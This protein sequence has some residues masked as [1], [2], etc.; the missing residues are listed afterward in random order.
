MKALW[1]VA[2]LALA[3]LIFFADII[4][5]PDIYLDANPFH[6]DPWRTYASQ[7]D[8]EHRTYRTDSFVTYLPRR[9]ELTRSLRQGRFPLWNP[10][11][12]GGMPFFADPQTRVLY[13]LAL[14]LTG[15]DPLRSMGYDV[16]IHIFIA[17]LGMFL[18]MR[19]IKISILGSLAAAFGYAFSSFFYVRIGHPTFVATASWIPFFFLGFERARAHG[20]QGVLLLALSFVLGYLAGFPQVFLFGV[21]SVV[22]YGF[23]LA[24]M[25]Q[26]EPGRLRSLRATTEVFAIAGGLALLLVCVQLIPFVELS[27][28]SVGLSIDLSQMKEVFVTPP[29]LLL[30]SV[31]PN[32]FGNPVEGTDWSDL[33]REL[34]HP[35]NPDFT[36]YCGIA[37]LMLGLVS[38]LHLKR[39]PRIQVLILLLLAS[40]GIATSPVLVSIAYK[41]SPVFRAS[42]ISRIAVVSCF[43][44]S[45]L[46]GMGFDFLEACRKNKKGRRKALAVVL[47]I[48]IFAI[49]FALFWSIAGR[50]VIARYA[51]KAA[52]VPETMW[53]RLHSYTRS[54]LIKVW[55]QADID[56]WFGYEQKQIA[57]GITFAALSALFVLA[58]TYLHGKAP[59][60]KILYVLLVIFIFSDIAL[61]AKG[62]FV[63]QVP[64]CLFETRGIKFLKDAL[65]Q[66]GTWRMMSS[67]ITKAKEIPVLP[68]NTNLLFSLFACDGQSTIVP[69]AYSDLT[70]AFDEIT[71]PSLL[72]RRTIPLQVGKI[73]MSNLGCTRYVLLSRYSKMFVSNPIL[74]TIGQYEETAKNLRIV[75]L[76]GN[77]RLAID[78]PPGDMLNLKMEFPDVKFLDFVVGFN[79]N[80]KSPGDT[81]RFGIVCEGENSS[82]KALIEFD[83]LKDR[84]KWHPQRLDVSNLSGLVHLRLGWNIPPASRV[85]ANAYWSGIDLVYADCEPETIPGGYLIRFPKMA[86]SLR[87]K[88]KTCAR[89]VPLEV[90]FSNSHKRTWWTAF[91]GDIEEREIA[92][93][94]REAI[95]TAVI[96]H[97]D[98]SFILKGAKVIY[99]GDLYQGYDLVYDRDMFIY[100]NHLA[101]NKGLCLDRRRVDAV[102][103][104]TIA[105]SALADS[106]D[107]LT[108]GTSTIIEYRPEK[109]VLE[110]SCHK[111]CYLLFQDTWYPGW[112][113][114][115]DGN[116]VSIEA[117][118]TG[119]RAIALKAGR[120]RVRMWFEPD[121][122]KLGLMLTL[123]G[124]GLTVAYASLRRNQ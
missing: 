121:S 38:T 52:T 97:S 101:V 31:F 70:L 60:R 123:L 6:Y 83:L 42:R 99:D 32:F 13:P 3:T 96:L 79:S 68:P 15:V 122:L 86:K 56:A 63:T 102:N 44:L 35:Y 45:A 58:L 40:I 115:V 55:S 112:R 47:A 49:C 9:Y 82:S 19:E 51:A 26:S 89:E 85:K 106:L 8:L 94:I 27:R 95:G 71:P 98:S 113:A 59:L 30:R 105:I 74:R 91:P 108:C 62:Y 103:A 107:D 120:H 109:V 4:F 73:L 28:N 119:M 5:G 90:F 93:D 111:D 18:F 29:A 1:P 11:I 88:L 46:A 54:G 66:P 67:T 33:P 10:Y 25:D 69:K 104:D 39:N 36:V 117:T 87:L 118:D 76:D 37:I 92:V 22:I 75:S 78:Q 124:L 77:A 100:E 65:G 23:Y 24:L 2:L 81:I 20:K 114:T 48:M 50:D 21:G 17:M 14:L 72:R 41:T 110:A 61:T 16:A 43:S 116:E 34:I 57:R 7:S 80:A 64:D 84:G 12:F 53:A